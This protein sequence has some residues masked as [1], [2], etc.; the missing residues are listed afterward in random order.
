MAC[1][2]FTTISCYIAL[3]HTAPLMTANLVLILGVSA[4]PAAALAAVDGV[5]R[6][7]CAYALMLIVNIAVPYGM[8]IIGHSLRIDVH[9][10]DRDALTGLFPR[11]AF[12]QKT[13]TLVAG[14]RG[15]AEVVMAMIDLDKFKQLNDTH[16]HAKGDVVLVAVARALSE[17]ADPHAV[18]GRGGG[19]ESLVA[20]IVTDPE[21]TELGHRLCDIVAALPQQL[22]VSVGTASVRCE[23]IR[24]CRSGG[25]EFPQRSECRTGGGACT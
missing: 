22:S 3:F 23:A 7:G 15:N 20:N 19:E 25:G 24:T 14:R 2:A 5:V 17:H 6:P 9:R 4:V 11:R 21:A 10:A 1:T 13:I 12:Y 18:V 16:G 8:Q